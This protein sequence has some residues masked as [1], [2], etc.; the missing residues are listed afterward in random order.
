MR[1]LNYQHLLYFWTVAR[2]GSIARASEVL[3]LT[4]QTISGQIK[5]LEESVGAPLFHRVGRGLVL[6]D[7]GRVVNQYADEIFSLGAELSQRVR[8]QDSG[9]PLAFNVGIVNSIPKLIA[10]RILLPALGLGDEIRVLCWENELERLLADLA[11]HRLDLVVSDRPLPTGSSVKAFNH[12]LGESGVAMFAEAELAKRLGAPRRRFPEILDGAPMLLP[13][14]TTA[15][16][17]RLDDWFDARELRPQIVGEFED[18]ALL[19]AFGSEG[20]GVFPAPTAIASQ[21][22][23]T[24]HSQMI[25]EVEGVEERF[26]VISPERKLKHPAVVRITETARE[27]LFE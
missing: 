9:A 12:L 20:T 10:Q 18:S 13:V 14:N 25:G 8:D 27:R 15:L 21:I 3:H 1:H 2:E 11:V 17:R 19:K 22:E 24:Y 26:Y 16:R 7:T 4:P 5:L 6:S 23:A